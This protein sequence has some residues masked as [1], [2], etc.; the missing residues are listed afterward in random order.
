[1]TLTTKLK[2]IEQS[3]QDTI[4]DTTTIH[5]QQTKDDLLAQLQA[6]T[7]ASKIAAQKADDTLVDQG[8]GIQVT[9]LQK[10][11]TDTV[12]RLEKKID[13]INLNRAPLKPLATTS[14]LDVYKQ[15]LVL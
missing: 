8:K 4:D 3:I 7:D 13:T 5:T 6:V 14:N 12:D 15:Y 10:E 2:A 1:V 9:D 11:I